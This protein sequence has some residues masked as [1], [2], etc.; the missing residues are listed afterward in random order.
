MKIQALHEQFF[1][2]FPITTALYPIQPQQMKSTYHGN[3]K[4]FQH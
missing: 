2:M 3:Q 4:E 1:A